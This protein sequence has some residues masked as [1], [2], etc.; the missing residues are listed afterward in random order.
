M[1]PEDTTRE[2]FLKQMELFKNMPSDKRFGLT[3]RL[4]VY[5]HKFTKAGI[6]ARHPEYSDEEVKL[7]LIKMTLPDELFIKVYPHAKD[8]FL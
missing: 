7:A 4:I 3:S 1:I 2:A 6:R 8:K 5:S